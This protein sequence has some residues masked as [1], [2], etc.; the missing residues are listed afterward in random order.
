[1]N[2]HRS[3]VETP[4]EICEQCDR[5]VAA[6]A[7]YDDP[8]HPPGCE[9]SH[10]VLLC[11]VDN[12]VPIDWRAECLRLRARVQDYEDDCQVAMAER[13]GDDRVH[14][15]CVPALRRALRAAE[16]RSA[17]AL[18]AWLGPQPACVEVRGIE[19]GHLYCRTVTPSDALADFIAEEANTCSQGDGS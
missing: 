10:C 11:W 3:D 8:A 5:Q 16:R 12:C 17:A 1:M 7:D 2:E 18:V 4:R 13:C 6:Q 9:C 15:T 14:C 19:G